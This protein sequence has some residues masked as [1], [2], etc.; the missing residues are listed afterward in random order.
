[1][2]VQFG[3]KRYQKKRKN[4]FQKWIVQW[5]VK[6][7]FSTYV[8]TKGIYSCGFICTYLCSN[9]Y[10]CH[11]IRLTNMSG[12]SHQ[13][14]SCFEKPAN[15]RANKGWHGYQTNDRYTFFKALFFDQWTNFCRIF[16][17]FEWKDKQELL[18]LVL[19]VFVEFNCFLRCDNLSEMCRYVN[20][21]NDYLC[22]LLVLNLFE[23]DL[24]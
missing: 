12:L 21:T 17:H 8:L 6:N 19:Y 15:A 23:D 5:A 3:R 20:K 13:L 24:I 22:K 14:F 4:F 10:E 18:L 7:S 1:M 11:N 16:V 2:I 9:K